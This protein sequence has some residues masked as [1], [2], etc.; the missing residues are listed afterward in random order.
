MGSP[1]GQYLLDDVLAGK[2]KAKLYVMLNAWRLSA[3]QRQDLLAG[4]S[5]SDGHLV[6]C[7]GLPLDDGASLAAMKQLTGFDIQ[8]VSPPK[9]WATIARRP[10]PCQFR[11][12]TPGR[13]PLR[14]GRRQ[15]QRDPGDVRGQV[16][17]HR[18]PPQ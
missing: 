2:V 7:A 14:R 3:A 5:R 4:D 6:L 9:A 1:Y 15:R 13:A 11:R 8:S 16:P 18:H 10:S 17:G 12:T